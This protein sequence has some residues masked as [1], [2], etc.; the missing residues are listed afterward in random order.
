MEQVPSPPAMDAP[1]LLPPAPE[2]KSGRRFLAKL[3]SFCLALFLLDGVVS[4]ADDALILLFGVHGLSLIRGLISFSTLVM[5]LGLYLLIGLTPAVPKRIFLPIPLFFLASMLAMFTLA[6]FWYHHLEEIAFAVSACE[7]MLGVLLVSLSRKEGKT[8]KPL[9]KQEQLGAR[10]FSWA[11]LL[12][13]VLL[14]VFVLLPAIAVYLFSCGAHAV[15]HFSEGF[16]SL[17][18][19][20]FTVQ[21]RKYVRDDG[22]AIQLFPMAHVAAPSFYQQV[23]KSFPTNAVILMEGVSDEGNLLTNKI[24]Y[25]R[26]AKTLGLAEQHETFAPNPQEVVRAD[27]DVG[28]FSRETIDFLNLIMLFH[29]RGMTPEN[30]SKFL[31][32]NP[33]PGFEKRLFDDLLVKRNEHLLG[34]IRAHLETSDNI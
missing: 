13:F 28:I 19:R 8:F 2:K 17:H 23:S 16:M 9:V 22:K 18:P 11:N 20:G 34:E 26:M 7:L 32:F 24:S 15:N 14:N 31:Q 3:L 1:P 21:V 33:P 5:A 27:V 29:S 6:I 4:F 10:G 30:L 25:K 12:G